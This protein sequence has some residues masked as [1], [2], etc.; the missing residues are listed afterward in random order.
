MSGPWF[1]WRAKIQAAA[2]PPINIHARLTRAPWSST[3]QL[4]RGLN[5]TTANTRAAAM[6]PKVSGS[7]SDKEGDKCGENDKEERHLSL[8]R[9][10]VATA[11]GPKKGKQRKPENAFQQGIEL[12]SQKAHAIST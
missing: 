3:C 10:L 4:P 9:S 5:N 12:R 2:S 7:F 1:S 8:I 11:A 6:N